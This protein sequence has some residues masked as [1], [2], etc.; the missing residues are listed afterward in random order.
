V[1][2]APAC[3]L[4]VLVSHAGML[5]CLQWQG[6]QAGSMHKA[7]CQFT[8]LDDAAVSRALFSSD[9]IGT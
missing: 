8:S 4:P 3:D 2:L 5:E 6:A 1:C 9:F 7:D